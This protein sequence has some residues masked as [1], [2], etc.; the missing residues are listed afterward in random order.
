[1]KHMKL[2]L[3]SRC[4]LSHYTVTLGLQPTITSFIVAFVGRCDCGCMSSS[5]KS[6][7]VLLSLSVFVIPSILFLKGGLPRPRGDRSQLPAPLDCPP[8]CCCAQLEA[9][10]VGPP[11]PHPH[12]PDRPWGRQVPQVPRGW[13]DLAWLGVACLGLARF[14]LAWV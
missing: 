2:V 5:C 8:P 9:P 3:T 4:V 6:F 10:E 12:L 13:H 11:L 1:M 7:P 14:G